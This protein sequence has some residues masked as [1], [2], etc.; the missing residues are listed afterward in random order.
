[1]KRPFVSLWLV[2]CC[3]FGCLAALEGYGKRQEAVCGQKA[4]DLKL[5]VERMRQET[6][7]KPTAVHASGGFVSAGDTGQASAYHLRRLD[8]S[9]AFQPFRTR[10]EG[11][12]TSLQS[13]YPTGLFLVNLEPGVNAEP[14]QVNW[15]NKWIQSF[16]RVADWLNGRE[17]KSFSYGMLN[18]FQI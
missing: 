10:V 4:A 8:E 3:L 5:A 15:G 13:M 9:E 7:G 12:D 2:V 6:V 17:G 1:M 18:G 11:V 16:Y 14:S